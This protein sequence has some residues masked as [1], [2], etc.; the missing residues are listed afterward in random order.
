M[1]YHNIQETLSKK[2]VIFLSCDDGMKEFPEL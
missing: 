2:G 1:A